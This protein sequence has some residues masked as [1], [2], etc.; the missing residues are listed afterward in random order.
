MLGLAIR[1]RMPSAEDFGPWTS[2]A[3]RLVWHAVYLYAAYKLLL[4]TW[5]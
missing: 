4:V 3:C 5:P 1:A 2:R